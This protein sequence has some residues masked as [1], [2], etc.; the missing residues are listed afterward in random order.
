MRPLDRDGLRLCKIQAELFERSVLYLDMSSE[1]FV[2]R[3]MKSKV[4]EEFDSTA[5]L[6]D[7]KSI[8]DI[9]KDL[10]D[11]YGPSNYGSVKYD[12]DAMHWAGYFYRCFAYTYNLSSA[13]V[14]KFLPLKVVISV[15]EPYHTLDIEQSIERLLEDKNISFKEED[16]T[17]KGVEL[18]KEIR[19][20]KKNK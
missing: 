1:I 14:Y 19:I 16:L 7:T 18:L 5:I 12:L 17:K 2:R 10:D 20:K 3:F 13:Q 9:F 8:E 6:D 4:A 11:Q 15:Y